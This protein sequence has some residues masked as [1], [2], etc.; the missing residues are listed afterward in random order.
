MIISKWIATRPRLDSTHVGHAPNS[1]EN[2]WT[3]TKREQGTRSSKGQAERGQIR[4]QRAE[5]KALV[6][7]L[8]IQLRGTHTSGTS[9]CKSDPS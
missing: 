4:L 7:G 1:S 9:G 8:G 5:R 2:H 3:G 6:L